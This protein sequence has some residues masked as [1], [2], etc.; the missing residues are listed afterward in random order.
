[1][2][3]GGDDGP[4]DEPPPKRQRGTSFTGAAASATT[5]MASPPSPSLGMSS[6]REDEQMDVP[7][8]PQQERQPSE[9]QPYQ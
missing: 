9:G 8:A 6:T 3:I 4:G 5:E 1:M 2:D 7:G